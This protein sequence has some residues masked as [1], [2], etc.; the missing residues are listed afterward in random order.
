MIFSAAL[1]ASFVIG[2]G[3]EWVPLVNGKEI[4]VGS[5]LDFSVLALQ[6]APAGKHGWVLPVGDHFEFEGLRGISQRFYGVNLCM[7]AAFPETDEAAC[8]AERLKRLGYNAIRLHH[9]DQQWGKGESERLKMDRLVAECIRCGIYVTTDLYVSRRVAWREIGIDR[10]GEMNMQTFKLYAQLHEGAFRNWQAFARAFLLRLNPFTGRRYVDEP[11]LVSLCALNEGGFY[12]GW[13]TLGK[14][15]EPV[16]RDAWRRW[17]LARRAADPSFY[18]SADLELPPRDYRKPRDS[19]VA[20]LFFADMEGDFYR[21]AAKFLKEELG[22][23]ALLTNDN[24]GV[25]PTPSLRVADDFDFVEEHFYKDHPSFLG[26]SWTLPSRLPNDNPLA[27]LHFAPCVS[28]FARLVDRPF[29]VSEW[30]YTGPAQFR[31]AGGLLV[32]TMAAQQGWSG[33]WRFSYAQ[34]RLEYDDSAVYPKFF[35]LARD[36]LAQASDRLAVLLYLR[37]DVAELPRWRGV[38]LETTDE[39]LTPPEGTPAWRA[40]PPWDDISWRLRVGSTLSRER[41]NGWGL[42]LRRQKADLKGVENDVRRQTEKAV[43]PLALDRERLTASLITERTVA[44]FA[45]TG[46]VVTAGVLEA[47]ISGHA[48]LVF[49]ASLDGS[50]IASSRRLL[51]SHLT[52][53]QGEGTTYR[54]AT[55]TVLESWGGQ[56]LVAS[57]RADLALAAERPEELHV[58]A[59]ATDGTSLRPVSARTIGGKLHFSTEIGPA[60]PAAIY[61]LVSRGGLSKLK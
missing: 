15:D 47:R 29:T 40:S 33:V 59:L 14:R 24:C 21:K 22:V 45:S 8:L 42:V 31:A 52:D 60:K 39:S 28:A 36:P 23:R 4:V 44:A 32:G 37:G 51:V 50:P 5:A 46:I 3:P 35:E 13:D 9:H 58:E 38:A 48:A 26:K 41:A 55:R 27:A 43:S 2:R 20:R 25:H 56:P 57:G 53:V 49:A 10:D 7:S 34:D 54:D 17:L 12:L 19:A 61:Y 6:D 16:V 18:P 30:N 1:L 11:A